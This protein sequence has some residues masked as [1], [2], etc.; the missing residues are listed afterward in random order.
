MAAHDVQAAYQKRLAKFS[1]SFLE[2]VDIDP[3]SSMP[4][5]CRSTT[6]ED[7]LA[8]ETLYNTSLTTFEEYSA[9]YVAGWLEKEVFS[10]FQ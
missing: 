10:G 7:A 3:K 1:A 8:V 9:A 5:E 4:H 6:Y 2:V